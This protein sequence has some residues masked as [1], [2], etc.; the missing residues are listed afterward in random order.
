MS[1]S[2]QEGNADPQTREDGENLSFEALV[3]ERTRR[4][5]PE[6]PEETEESDQEVEEQEEPQGLELDLDDEEET[7]EQTEETEEEIDL[8]SLSPEQIQELAKKGKSR[9]LHRV[10]ELT[11]QKKALE[12]KLQ[13]AQA[14]SKPLPNIPAEENPFRELKSLDDV[15]SKY[16]ELEKVL[17]ETDRLL[18][19]HEDY[20]ADDIIDFGGREFSKKQIRQANRNARNSLTKYLPAQAASIQQVEAMQAMAGQYEEAITRE[21]PEVFVQDSPTAKQ[22][23]QLQNDPLI[24]QIRVKIPAL[25]PQINYI[26]AHAVRS[27]HQKTVR[28]TALATGENKLRTKVPS[29]PF[30]AG[31]ARSSTPVRKS[32]ESAVK[33]FEESGSPEDWIAARI[34]KLSK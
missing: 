16:G 9:L 20:G 32:V 34:A 27:I 21:V 17:E 1:K 5:E 18:E 12:E 13:S 24:E 19:D 30:G 7:E 8:L 10:G 23:V 22:F 4:Y 11:A 3:A 14:E 2:N 26:L 31:A 28:K 25:A 15:K 6:E 29:D 33:R